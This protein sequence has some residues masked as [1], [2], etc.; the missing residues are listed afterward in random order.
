MKNFIKTLSILVLCLNTYIVEAQQSDTLEIQRNEMGKVNFARFKPNPIWKMQ[1][2]VNFLKVILQMDTLDELH[3]I[4]DTT[5]KLNISHRLYQQYYRGIKV[6]NAEY[7]V[8]GKNGIIESINGDFQDV[9]LPT[10]T[11]AI[12]EQEALS[13]ALS[14]VNAKE[15]KWEDSASERFIK[16]NTNKSNATYYPEGELVITKDLLKGGKNLKLAWKF[17]I[18]SLIPNNEQWVYV[19]AIS[20]IVIRVTPL[21]EDVN[22]PCTAQTKYSGILGI[23][24]DSFAGN[25]RLRENRNGVNVQTMN[26]LNQSN[27]ANAIDFTNSNTSWTTGSWPNI[28]QDQ[29]ALDAH[30]GAEMES[31]AKRS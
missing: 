20:G 17:T 1:N 3:L 19:D 9:K 30:W 23:T 16:Q 12:N 6:E 26:C 15:Y 21:I 10:T 11:P 18:S 14:F 13:K 28:G 24:G 29:V 2:A 4:R 22:T 7:L 8:H 5:D 27:Y 31:E 25:F